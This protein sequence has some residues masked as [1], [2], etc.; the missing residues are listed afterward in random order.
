M[1]NW[2]KVNLTWKPSK[3][4]SEF[5]SLPDSIF[6]AMYGGAAGGG[7]SDALL[8][9]PMVREFYKY[10][11][12]KALVLRR[13]YP[14]LEAELI[15]RSI[16]GIGDGGPSYKHFG[17]QYNQE[18][19][20]WVFPSGAIIQ[21]GHAEYDSDVRK[22]DSA[23]YNYIGFDELTSFTEYQYTY[24]FSRCR[25]A[26]DNL[27][28]FI[29]SGT[30]PGGVGHGWVRSRFVEPAPYGTII[31]DTRTKSKRIFIQAKLT[32]NP[33]LM[34]NDPNYASR[35]SMM[36]ERDRRAKL[37]GDWWTFSGQVF[38][39]Y[40]E[41]PF[42]DEPESAKHVIDAFDIPKW[43]PKFLSVDW[44]YSAA[45]SAHWGALSPDDRLYVY[46][47]YYAKQKKISEW[48]TEIGRQSNGETFADVVMCR[49]AW[50]DRGEESLIVEQFE[51]Y[52][53]LRPRMADNKRVAGKLLL[54][55]YF[56]WRPKSA[57]K[58]IVGE[59]NSE[60]AST[61][62]RQ[63]G[64]EAYKEYLSSFEPEKEENNLPK[65]QIF[66]ECVELRRIIP[67]CV[68]DD[69]NPEDVAEFP[70][71]DPY[72]DFRYLVE[73]AD[74]YRGAA[75]PQQVYNESIADAVIR[76]EKT[77]DWTSYHQQMRH[78]EK[79]GFTGPKAVKRFH[80]GRAA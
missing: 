53:G 39:D 68:Y 79:T 56:R 35:L 52:S 51:N 57:R 41:Q 32:D 72:D 16:S 12:F 40:R 25:S 30:N 42:N 47:E 50:Q 34:K 73:C 7:K 43:W 20:R 6:E 65:V 19:K 28:A 23:E 4:Q 67:L 55:E 69:K 48:S 45:T 8:M 78:I 71:D 74:R 44:G 60:T 11:K 29:R 31:I 1:E 77:R 18:K 46:R 61:I 3:R 33:H 2:L 75:K 14:E 80:R 64:L 17:G 26:S 70:G 21:F 10:P 66:R 22:Y 76:L 24:L 49:S 9:L 58:I 63:H 27:P 62:L 36:P 13:T 38:D 37:D 59:Y 54:Q 15:N 5:L